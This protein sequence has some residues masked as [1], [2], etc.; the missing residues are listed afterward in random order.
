M[1]LRALMESTE[2]N[3][4]RFCDLM[5]IP[6]KE[7]QVHPGLG[8]PFLRY[9]QGTTPFVFVMAYD[10]ED[11]KGHFHT[12]EDDLATGAFLQEAFQIGLRVDVDAVKAAKGRPSDFSVP[13]IYCYDNGNNQHTIE[14]GI[15]VDVEGTVVQHG[16]FVCFTDAEMATA[17]FHDSQLRRL[18]GGR[19]NDFRMLLNNRAKGLPPLRLSVVRE[20]DSVALGPDLK[21]VTSI[22]GTPLYARN[23]LT[24]KDPVVNP[25]FDPPIS[26]VSYNVKSLIDRHGTT[27]LTS[28]LDSLKNPR[29]HVM[30]ITGDEAPTWKLSELK[31]HFIIDPQ[32]GDLADVARDYKVSVA[33]IQEHP[34]LGFPFFKFTNPAGKK[35]LN[36][37]FHA[38]PKP[39]GKIHYAC[40]FTGAL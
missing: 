5:N 19:W 35:A 39:G 17:S 40:A 21:S 3:K 23:V 15:R 6:L 25:V 22:T 11:K 36:L 16:D 4:N 7:L 38:D 32:E 29:K 12:W 1:P 26:H 10:E 37:V 33:D 14:P 30:K 28:I 27:V 31:S 20:P 18:A 8:E 34:R 9:L 24:M 2:E 13:P